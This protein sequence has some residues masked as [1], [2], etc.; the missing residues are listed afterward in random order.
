MRSFFAIGLTAAAL[1]VIALLFWPRQTRF[2]EIKRQR[3]AEP[4]SPTPI[5][6]VVSK[7]RKMLHLATMDT[8]QRNYL[9]IGKAQ[10][11]WSL[12][13]T[14][15]KTGWLYFARPKSNE[16]VWE[17]APCSRANLGDVVPVDLNAEFIS[18]GDTNRIRS[19]FDTGSGLEKTAGQTLSGRAIPV[20]EGQVLLARLIIA[21]HIVY[22]IR[23]IDQH[24]SEDWG[25]ISVEYLTI[26]LK[27]A[28]SA[29]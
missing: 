28:G 27:E 17:F 16:P 18:E 10:M 9:S 12:G 23:L 11:E 22:A 1:V 3:I 7:T 20:K 29:R 19:A 21:P 15:M 14:A 4:H 6:S 2:G 8:R 26:D 5:E 25:G 24:G 13:S